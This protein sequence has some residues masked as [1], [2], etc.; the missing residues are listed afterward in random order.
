[1]NSCQQKDRTSF[2]AVFLQPRGFIFISLANFPKCLH[3]GWPC[4]LWTFDAMTPD[5]QTG[6]AHCY[7]S[8]MDVSQTQTTHTKATVH[9]G[10]SVYASALWDFMSTLHNVY[11]AFILDQKLAEAL[12]SVQYSEQGASWDW[13]RVSLLFFLAAVF[14]QCPMFWNTTWQQDTEHVTQ[15]HRIH[16]CTHTFYMFCVCAHVL[17]DEDRDT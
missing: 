12:S 8:I 15:I 1:M 11:Y 7:Q 17:G 13:D 3:Q 14:H 16:T 10:Y 2:T 6:K 5:R 4:F 9:Y